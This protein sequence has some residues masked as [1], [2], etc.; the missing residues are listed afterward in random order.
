MHPR[1]GRG[2][3]TADAGNIDTG[4]VPAHGGLPRPGAMLHRH[5]ADPPCGAAEAAGGGTAAGRHGGAGGAAAA[6]GTG[7]QVGHP[8]WDIRQS[9][10]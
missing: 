10:A 4:D 3:R 2:D 8:L 6:G 7:K 9:S 1:K 5:Y